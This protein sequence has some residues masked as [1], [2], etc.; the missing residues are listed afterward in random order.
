MGGRGGDGGGKSG[1]IPLE[2]R[3]ARLLPIFCRRA[4]RGKPRLYRGALR[5]ADLVLLG[6]DGR[7]ARPHRNLPNMSFSIS[8]RRHRLQI[9][10]DGFSIAAL[11]AKLGNR[12]AQT[13]AVGPDA[14]GQEFD[15]VGVAGGWS[16]ANPLSVDWP[17]R[18]GL[19]RHVGNGSALKPSRTIE[20]SAAV[21]RGEAF[22]AH[23]HAFDEILSTSDVRCRAAF[24][25]GRL[26][27]VA[28]SKSHRDPIR[29][30]CESDGVKD[31][32]ERQ[33]KDLTPS[34]AR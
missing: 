31:Q 1:L 13:T 32:K 5:G 8:L 10:N 17:V 33:K 4:R 18:I 30:H 29:E 25:G 27:V 2:T 11:H 26:R 3:L 22:A 24:F 6:L 21:A 7:D 20:V 28:L 16:A 34:P 9:G 19:R 12:K 14:G 15:H 23:G